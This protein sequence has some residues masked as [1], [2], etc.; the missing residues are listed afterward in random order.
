MKPV[1]IAIVGMGTVGGATIHIL[2]E[3]AAELERK[4]GFKLHLRVAASLEVEA[5]AE[6]DM[7][8]GK[9]LLTRDWREA[10]EHPEVDIVVEVVGGTSIAYEVQKAALERGRPVVSANKELLGQRGAELAQIA[11]DHKTSL[12]MEASAGG[13]IPI[14]NAL[15]EGIAADR[16]EAV[17]GILNG[18]CN[19]ILTE[20]EKTG[21][22]FASILAEAQKRGYAEAKPEADVEGYDARSKLA[23][24]ANFCFGARVPTDAI[25]RQ[26]ITKITPTDFA[27]AH[28][29]GYTIRLIAAGARTGAQGN[30]DLSLYVR[31][32]LVPLTAMLAKVQG[33]YNAIWVKGKYGEDTLYYGRGAG[34]P[35]G[36]AVVSDIMSAARDLRH[37]SSLR[38]PAFGYWAPQEIAKVGIEAGT[39][40]YFLRFLVKDEVGIIAKLANIIADEK[41]NIDAVFEEPNQDADNLAFVISVKPTSETAVSAALARMEKLSFLREPPL[42]LPMENILAG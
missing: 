30:D 36:V 41:I 11:Y 7:P 35:T 21:A 9:R 26:G 40:P 3:N 1:N 10:V 4:L 31:P 6:I 8:G 32:V 24:V 12:H 5:R 42:A 15:R 16:I 27:Y 20:I 19:F 17:Y 14:L 22:P 23:I 2:D 33:S 37:G 28:R 25:Y 18:T 34:K 38:A 13:G 39:R 29:L